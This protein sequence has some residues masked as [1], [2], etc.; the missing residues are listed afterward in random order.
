MRVYGSFDS[1]RAHARERRLQHFVA[2]PSRFDFLH[3]NVLQPVAVAERGD[4]PGGRRGLA[5]TQDISHMLRI[6]GETERDDSEITVQHVAALNDGIR[7][8]IVV[9]NSAALNADR[10]LEPAAESKVVDTLAKPPD[11]VVG[12]RHA[13]SDDSRGERSVDDRPHQLLHASIEGCLFRQSRGDE[14]DREPIVAHEAARP[15]PTERFTHSFH[16]AGAQAVT[17][18]EDAGHVDCDVPRIAFLDHLFQRGPLFVAPE[19]GVPLS[20][21]ANRF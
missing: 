13:W 10:R 1:R 3:H 2:G 9:E 17:E 16:L 5:V 4:E 6:G 15:F 11:D 14:I 20:R 8:E 19:L 21:L 18:R 7:P 12:A